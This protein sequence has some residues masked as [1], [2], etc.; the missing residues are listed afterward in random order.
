VKSATQFV[1]LA[2]ELPRGK[3]VPLLVRRE[4]ESLYLAVRLPE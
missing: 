4:N 1:E 3:A 2:K